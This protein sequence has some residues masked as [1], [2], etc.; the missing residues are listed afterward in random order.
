MIY[1]DPNGPQYDLVGFVNFLR[2]Y[3]A[4]DSASFFMPRQEIPMQVETMQIE[5]NQLGLK[6]VG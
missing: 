6:V 4:E 3:S 1:E 5:A 2:D